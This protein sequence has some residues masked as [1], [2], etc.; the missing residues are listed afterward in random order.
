M[1]KI[2]NS[3]RVSCGHWLEDENFEEFL[4][5][6]KEYKDCIEQVAFFTSYFHPPMP[7]EMAKEHCEIIKGR[8]ERVREEGFSCGMNILSTVG[9][10]PER[11]EL[12]L[13]GNWAYM[14]NIDG[15][16]C[17]G[18]RCMYNQAYLEEYVRPLY[19]IHCHANPD[20][21]WIDDDVRFSHYPIVFGCFCEHCMEGFNKIYG[22]SY[23]RESLKDAFAGAD[24]V[25]LRK[26]WLDFQSQKIAN[27]LG[28]IRNVVNSV[29]DT[30][31]LGFMT[32]ERFFEGFNVPLWA[33]ALSEH[34]KYEIMWRPGGGA[35]SDA[36][37]GDFLNK[38]ADIGRQTSGL[39]AYVTS[40]QS[41]IENCPYQLL[42]KS[43]RSTALETLI[44]LA[45]GSNGTALNFLP[46]ASIGES[47]GLIQ[48]HMDE[49]RKVTPF[50]KRL[51]DTFDLG[52][53]IGIHNGWHRY[54]NAAV[55]GIFTNGGCG[56]MVDYGRELYTFGLPEAF[57]FEQAT[58]YTMASRSP[59]AFSH[60]EIMHILSKGVFLDYEAV[61]ALN[62]LGYGEYVGF[63]PGR[64]ELNCEP[65]EV[66]AEHPLNEGLVGKERSLASIFSKGEISELLPNEGAEV[67]CYL[68]SK[69]VPL[70]CKKSQV[71]DIVAGCSMGI[72][73]NTLGG[74]VCATSYYSFSA[75]SDSQKTLQLK[76]IFRELSKDALP[77][78]VETYARVHVVARE[79][80]SG[81][82]FTIL[83]MNLDTLTEIVVLVNGHCS[84]AI[85]TDERCSETVLEAVGYD[86]AMTRFVIPKLQPYEMY[87]VSTKEI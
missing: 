69:A 73:H 75:I 55:P 29:D 51:S 42:N 76:R 12:T 70:T 7:L 32:G 68:Q 6:I 5:F 11:M 82:A 65:T 63:R 4:S 78:Y 47:I 79:A 34:G 30:I 85:L 66:Y 44:Y 1:T 49:V 41:E 59:Y 52:K 45:A 33:D 80:V 8:M 83:N 64:E 67:L 10:H 23:T 72:Y 21:I 57:S 81:N 28:F 19:E 46:E 58:C 13:K 53:T 31:T 48:A 14:T 2:Y 61:K 3:L 16:E 36:I 24:A 74:V 18:S 20:F 27:L 17:V 77:A 62:E 71:A 40:I 84:Q 86:G 54:T 38:S 22:Y 56:P 37:F 50:M 39:P 43:P 60:D 25:D 35:Y 9:H 87:L 15:E 26:Q